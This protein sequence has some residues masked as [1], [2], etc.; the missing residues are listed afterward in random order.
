MADVFFRADGTRS[1][2]QPAPIGGA[3]REK[4]ARLRRRRRPGTY[5][6]LA[7]LAP[8]SEPEGDFDRGGS[9]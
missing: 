7:R 3:D 6:K 2:M 8:L 1:R 5:C 9:G 4:Q